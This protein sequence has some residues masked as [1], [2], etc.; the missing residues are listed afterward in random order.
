M[1]D[2]NRLIYFI[3]RIKSTVVITYKQLTYR[4]CF[5]FI[6]RPAFRSATPTDL[7]HALQRFMVHLVGLEPTRLSAPAP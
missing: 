2:S 7:L 5:F 1:A 4:Q 3:R 6:S